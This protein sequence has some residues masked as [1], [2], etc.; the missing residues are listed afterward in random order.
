MSQLQ[1]E[2]HLNKT[3]WGNF[4]GSKKFM[5]KNLVPCERIQIP[6]RQP[7]MFPTM[8]KI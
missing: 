6:G 3:S 8:Y 5:C 7:K 1:V 2:L 4:Y